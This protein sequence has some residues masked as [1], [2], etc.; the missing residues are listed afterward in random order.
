MSPAATAERVWKAEP[1][2][3]ELLCADEI[4]EILYG[5]AKGGGKSDAL[6]IFNIRRRTKY[7]GSSGLIIRREFADLVKEGALIPRSKE[8]LTGIAQYNEQQHKWRFPNDS[9][10]EFGHA[11]SEHDILGYQGAQ[12]DDVCADQLEQFTEWQYRI[13]H[14]VARTTRKDLKPLLRATANPGD[15]G[16]A[17]VKAYFID[18][19]PPRTPFVDAET[20]LTRMFIPATLRDNPHLNKEY[21]QWLQSLPEPW[22]SAWVDGRW[23]VFIGQYFSPWQARAPYVCEPFDLPLQWPRWMAYDWG[24]ASPAWWGWLCRAP[25][26][27][28]YLY[29]ELYHAIQEPQSHRWVGTGLTVDRQ[30][31]A[32]RAVM[33]PD[34]VAAPCYAGGDVFVRSGQTGETNADVA[35]REGIS[36]VMAMT[37]R[38]QGWQRLKRAFQVRTVDR[39]GTTVE[40]PELVIFNTCTHIIRTLPMLAGNPHDMEDITDGQ[41]DHP[42]DGLRYGMSTVFAATTTQPPAIFGPPRASVRI[43]W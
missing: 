30:A 14:S 13:L 27:T 18:V 3:R 11:K 33:L 32:A 35:A 16:H 39:L 42:A 1:P 7:P 2:Q 23:D 26:G 31:S 25:W 9:V 8:L 10:I 37:N 36:M 41:E 34:E 24:S 43:P 15:I 6:L 21:V 29:R 12:Y 40:E 38:V 19:A 4:D 17:W 28:V 5:G 22:R 20:G